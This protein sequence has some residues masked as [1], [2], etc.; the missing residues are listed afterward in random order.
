MQ[1]HGKLLL[2]IMQLMMY[3]G[4]NSRHT[5]WHTTVVI[6]FLRA[7]PTLCEFNE[8]NDTNLVFA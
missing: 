1:I 7:T 4:A 3:A 8:Q 6:S 2:T 5:M